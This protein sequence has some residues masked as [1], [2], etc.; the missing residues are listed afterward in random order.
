M[1]SLLLAVWLVVG[2]VQ[3]SDN[4]DVTF[5]TR[6]QRSDDKDGLVEGHG[7][8]FA[9][10]LSGWGLQ[11]SNYLLTA[12]HN[13][14]DDQSKEREKLELEISKDKWVKFDVVWV[15]KEMDISVI[16]CVKALPRLTSLAA[17]DAHPH[18]KVTMLGSPQ[19]IPIRSYQGVVLKR[20]A[21]SFKTKVMIEFDHGDSGG[22]LFD[23]DNQII[24]MAVSGFLKE[25][26]L[27]LDRRYGGFIPVSVL[28]SF[29]DEHK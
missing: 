7:T 12:A 13:T 1:R 22:P 19:G 25:G 24:G 15:D 14:Y 20:F 26:E 2:A 18:D 29:L 3:A 23:K 16:R 5:R 28:R 21:D 10:D 4:L 9:V 11:G 27:E 6:Y 17:E 8:A